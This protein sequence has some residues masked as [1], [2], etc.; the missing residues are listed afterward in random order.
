MDVCEKM[1]ADRDKLR[2]AFQ[3]PLE[4]SP[5]LD[6]FDVAGQGPN[7]C[8]NSLFDP[9]G[10]F[11]RDWCSITITPYRHVSISMSGNDRAAIYDFSD[12]LRWEFSTIRSC[13]LGQIGRSRL[14]SLGQRAITAPFEAVTL[15][16]RDFIFDNAKMKVVRVCFLAEL[17]ARYRND[18]QSCYDSKNGA[19]VA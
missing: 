3:E 8:T 14:K 15:H 18:Q 11:A 5:F 12:F 13:D 9:S 7:L 6:R 2:S 4:L 17:K 1:H 10:A 19:P 16:A